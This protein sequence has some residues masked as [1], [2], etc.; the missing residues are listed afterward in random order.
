MIHSLGGGVIAENGYYTFVKAEAERI[1]WYVC[2]FEEVQAG[3]RVKLSLCGKLFEG[4]V[5]KVERGVSNQCAPV[6]MNR[7]GRVEE[8]LRAK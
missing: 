5:L 6:P 4:V 3:D 8:I 1:W 7:A 2:P